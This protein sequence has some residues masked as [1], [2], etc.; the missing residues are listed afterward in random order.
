MSVLPS[1]QRWPIEYPYAYQTCMRL[2]EYVSGRTVICIA[3]GPSVKEQ[4]PLLSLARRR[5]I[6]CVGVNYS[7]IA[8]GWTQAAT[9]Y[10]S[11]HIT[12]QTYRSYGG[13]LFAPMSLITG[14]AARAMLGA[15][16]KA[17]ET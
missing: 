13:L 4:L 15:H 6:F 11:E 16:L 5:G 17:H 3:E 7:A 2:M 8:L 12:E 1:W 14:T 10:D 9:F